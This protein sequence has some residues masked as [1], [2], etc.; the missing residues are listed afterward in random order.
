MRLAKWEE[1]E[2]F[3]D[4]A[5]FVLHRDTWISGYDS[6]ESHAKPG[7]F[8]HATPP[9]LHLL[10]HRDTDGFRKATM[11]RLTG[12]GLDAP[13]G[14]RCQWRYD[15][16]ISP[17]FKTCSDPMAATC[18]T[19]PQV[20]GCIPACPPHMVLDEVTHRCVHLEDCIKPVASVS[21]TTTA[22]QPTSETVI[23]ATTATATV[24]P[25]T[26]STAKTTIAE[27][28]VSRETTTSKV[29][30]APDA[31]TQPAATSPFLAPELLS[32]SQTLSPPTAPPAVRP[33]MVQLLSTA[34][35][36]EV[37]PAT[38]TGATAWMSTVSSS[39]FSP[40]DSSTLRTSK[41]PIAMTVLLR[42][43]ATTRPPAS[44]QPQ[45][46]TTAS[47]L[48]P[49]TTEELT[50][51]SVEGPTSTDSLRTVHPTKEV[52]A[53]T[54]HLV[55]DTPIVT[56]STPA[57]V[58]VSETSLVTERTTVPSTSISTKPVTMEKISSPTTTTSALPGLLST[59]ATTPSPVPSWSPLE[60]RTEPLSTI[61]S[62]KITES[63]TPVAS[64]TTLRTTT[65]MSPETTAL[66][67]SIG[68]TEKILLPTQPKPTTSTAT[69]PELLA[70]SSVHVAPT[71]AIFTARTSPTSHWQTTTKTVTTSVSPVISDTTTTSSALP[72][73]ITDTTAA[74]LSTSTAHTERTSWSAAMPTTKRTT[75]TTTLRLPEVPQIT[76][77][78]T[79][80]PVTI[81][82]T[83]MPVFLT[84]TTTVPLSP[85]TE[86]TTVPLSPLSETTTVPL[87]PL[88]E[89]T[90]L[91]LSPLTETITVPLSPLTETTTIPLSPLTETTTV[92]LSPL[93]ETTTVPLSPLTET[94]TVP[95]SPLTETTTVPLLLLSETTTIPLSPLTETATV[96]L[97]PLTE[98]TTVPLLPLTET[99]TVPLSPLTETTTVP[100]SPLTETTLP[101]SPLTETTTVPLLPLSETTTVP[102]SPLTETTTIP[103]SPLTETTTV[104][105]LPL[106]ATTTVPLS[107]LTETSTHTPSTTRTSEPWRPPH[108]ETSTTSDRMLSEFT[109]E[110]ITPVA[111]STKTTEAPPLPETSQPAVTTATSAAATT[112]AF[113]KTSSAE[114]TTTTTS[115]TFLTTIP[116]SP[117]LRDVTTTLRPISLKPVTETTHPVT[118]RVDVSTSVTTI[119][120]PLHPPS[121]TTT[122]TSATPRPTA[123]PEKVTTRL[124]STVRTTSAPTTMITWTMVPRTTP[125][126]PVTTRVTPRVTVTERT[127]TRLI[128]TRVTVA[129]R[130]SVVTTRSTTLG[131]PT[132][133][134][135][136]DTI[137]VPGTA[138][139]TEPITTASTTE[140]VPVITATPSHAP[141]S[142]PLPVPTLTTV[143]VSTA[144]S[145]TPEIVPTTKQTEVSLP[146]TQPEDKLTSTHVP[147]SAPTVTPRP[148]MTPVRATEPDR[149]YHTSLGATTPPAP[150][151]P[152][153]ETTRPTAEGTTSP[154][155]PTTRMCS[156]P[157]AEFI[158]ECTKYICVNNQLVLFNKSHSCPS[159]P[160]PPSCGL[161]G[162]AVL[163]N[164]DKCCPQWACPCRCSVFPD[165]NVITFDGNS[166]AVYKAASY[167][168]TQLRNETVSI[169]VQEC[170]ADSESHLLWNFTNLCLVA[171]SITHKS[172]HVLIH[173][174]QRRLYVNSRYAKPRF[175]KHGFEIYDTG[176]MYL[177]RSPAGL[178]LQWFHSTGMMVI[179][180][181][182][183][184]NRLHATGLCGFCDGD[185]AN[186]LTLANGTTV[187][188]NEDPA[189]FIDSW[190]VPNTT[191]YVSS[192]RRR[193]LNCSTSDCSRCLDMLHKHAFSPCH[194]FVPPSTFCE[195]WVRDAEYINNHCVALAA[196]AASCH[197]FNI[198]IEWRRADYC[199]FACPASLRYQA[200]LPACTAPS[201]PN[202]D[203]DSD[204]DH[205]SGLT[206]GCVCPEGTLLHRPYS[207][208]CISPNKCACTDS[209]GFP[210]A[211]G[212]V[213]KASMDGCCMYRCDNDT[214][215][216]VEYNCSSVALPTC[217]RAGEMVISLVDD[218]SC[219]P[220]KV[221]VCNHSLCD[222]LP[223][224]CKYGEK[225]VSYYRH[226]SCCP[227]YVCECDAD[228]CVL[229]VPSCRE[230][231]TL[232]SSRVGEGSCC[233]THICVCSACSETVP[234]CQDGEVLTVD[235][236][237]TDRCCPAYRCVCESYR[238]P[239][240]TCPD[241]MSVVSVSSQDRCCATQ[242]C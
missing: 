141:I 147:V 66:L 69:S 70:S 26:A 193:E 40:D 6:L 11:F 239:Q 148:A 225:L 189:V 22:A 220:Q 162:F 94:T 65:D 171:L 80:P 173:R 73:K 46:T 182:N 170:P 217:R 138:S 190:Q 50:I 210:R 20:E 88:T 51:S 45:V 59:L 204:P 3:W 96:P 187:S 121:R 55:M 145:A 23:S 137:T 7:F 52:T 95:L 123:Y 53:A 227:D 17:C 29:P 8:L 61:T 77:V 112:I 54:T 14:P 168:V 232:V 234:V 97:S 27:P 224:K 161:L 226:D 4:A 114:T 124:V 146:T 37:P 242:T 83:V 9:H 174:L 166:V 113:P 196:Y 44:L 84:E 72:L 164:G 135:R 71:T 120:P 214:I 219:C 78:S 117:P 104:P 49:S 233:L 126:I 42:L 188:V 151:Y 127:T 150:P 87:S 101:L 231:Q 205:C 100:L 194:A 223:P 32:T 39:I 64:F 184:I 230:D 74:P 163:V 10:K 158:D 63:V 236:N 221:C 110:T 109:S 215:V 200:C 159:S 79:G 167:I 160:N 34:K 86:T 68:T 82:P 143:T 157:Y 142:A 181:D 177:I 57:L 154:V 240:L 30:S 76:T 178:K 93:T 136:P 176:N 43:T 203:F 197:K 36:T 165:L 24:H 186:D 108:W 67:A 216:P 91:S 102:L 229:D 33:E 191:S 152:P 125:R 105:L 175:R 21:V 155:I 19:I 169:V 241:G 206:E 238:C 38:V 58:S 106:T 134:P 2:A 92:P 237:S 12:P 180:T 99:A 16:C 139:T 122:S 228:G 192:S 130:P 218:S 128:T 179:D 13:P 129:T 47:T 111:T 18:L 211:H 207:A 15:S 98:T 195:L 149:P 48:W 133:T 35:V 132:V 199:P 212:E 60:T 201:C 28:A 208:L 25:H 153:V 156:P 118:S 144:T 81:K 62:S 90:P 5:T 198:C 213:W 131:P 75:Q 85:L 41:L 116:T 1:S 235:G 172:N 119:L 115:E 140:R 89:S 31:P 202:H 107:P 103:L 185:P 222:F 56:T 183:A 209:S